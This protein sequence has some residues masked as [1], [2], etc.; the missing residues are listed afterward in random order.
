MV[1]AASFGYLHWATHGALLIGVLY[2]LCSHR[3]ASLGSRLLGAAY[4][5]SA[6]VLYLCALLLP[7]P[8]WPKHFPLFLLLQLVPVALFGV[9]LRVFSGPKWV[10]W[11]LGPLALVC[12]AWQA[13]LGHTAI[14][15]K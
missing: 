9:S 15:G 8:S 1:T 11:L 2:L 3:S 6:A 14:H 13:L 7:Q 10:H 12:L 5:P 4:A